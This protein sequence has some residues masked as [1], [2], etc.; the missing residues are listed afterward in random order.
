MCWSVGF[1]LG[2]AVVGWITCIYLWQRN[3]SPRDRWY[4]TYL[5]TYTLTQLVDI[6]LWTLHENTPLAACAESSLQWSTLPTDRAQIPQLVVSK[7]II[8][9]VVLVQHIAQ[10]QY[11][12]DNLQ[13]WR[14]TMIALHALP[15][16]GMCYQFACSDIVM[17][18]IPAPNTPTLRW[19]GHSAE[20]WQTLIV[21]LHVAVDFILTMPELSVRIAHLATFFSVVATLWFTEGTLA[22]GS[23]WCTYCLIFSFV[24]ATDPSKSLHFSRAELCLIS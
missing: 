3:Y 14:K 7:Y 1:S 5:V 19:G 23:K 17:S 21:V 16:V 15:L 12:S 11:P 6:V 2:S 18:A 10:L 24:Y 22:L 9:I 4:A 13:K 8:P 20:T